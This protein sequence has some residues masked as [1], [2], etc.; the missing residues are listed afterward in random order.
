MV[1]FKHR[2]PARGVL[3]VSGE[4]ERKSRAVIEQHS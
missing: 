2:G 1:L 3:V 4:K